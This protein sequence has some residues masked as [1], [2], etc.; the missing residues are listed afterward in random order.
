MICIGRGPW[1]GS[2]ARSCSPWLWLC[3]ALEKSTSAGS[4]CPES[5]GFC[6]ASRLLAGATPPW[7]LLAPGPAPSA[8]SHSQRP[9]HRLPP[10]IHARLLE[11]LRPHPLSLH[12]RHSQI[13]SMQRQGLGASLRARPPAQEPRGGPW[14]MGTDRP[15]WAVQVRT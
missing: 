1:L 6:H 15:R 4:P 10:K 11:P 14:A 3:L 13:R 9:H 5:P 2:V 7:S 8:S 12:C